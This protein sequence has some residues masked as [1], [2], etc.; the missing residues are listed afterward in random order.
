[1]TLLLAAGL[2]ALEAVALLVLAVLQFVGLGEGSVGAGVAWAVFFVLCAIGLAWCARGLAQQN[3]WARAPIVLVQ[4]IMLGLAW[5]GRHRVAL[6]VAL[7]LAAV[8]ALVGIF[9]PA[10]ISALESDED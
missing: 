9:H 4:L 8:V 3:S 7:L 6:A 1:V 10:S 5:D 2:A